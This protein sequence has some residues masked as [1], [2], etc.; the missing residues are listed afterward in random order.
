M[1]GF[2]LGLGLRR[3]AGVSAVLCDDMNVSFWVAL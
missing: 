1:S 2:Y 3:L